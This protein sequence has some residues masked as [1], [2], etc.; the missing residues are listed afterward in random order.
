MIAPAIPDISPAI[1]G[2]AWDQIG[3]PLV[4]G[5]REVYGVRGMDG[6]EYL[7]ELETWR[8][9]REWTIRRVGEYGPGR[10]CIGST[11]KAA[12]QHLNAF[13]AGETCIHCS[14][15]HSRRDHF[16][17]RCGRRRYA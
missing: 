8:G 10:V 9:F 13:H 6:G 16:C 15:V 7:A 17:D 1:G 5:S 3:P 14:H 12:V 11:L 4:D 2:N